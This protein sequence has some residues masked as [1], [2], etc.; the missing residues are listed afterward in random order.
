MKSRLWWSIFVFCATLNA[1]IGESVE[2][3]YG[4]YLKSSQEIGGIE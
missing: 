4:E 3:S 1:Y 2:W